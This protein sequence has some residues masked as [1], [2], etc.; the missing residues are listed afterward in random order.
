MK[1]ITTNVVIALVGFALGYALY[2]S[3]NNSEIKSTRSVNLESSKKVE[4]D[5]KLSEKEIE[6]VIETTASTSEKVTSKILNLKEK[7]EEQ[8]TQID[9]ASVTK[10]VG[11]V[12]K[13]QV[14]EETVI[15]QKELIEWTTQHTEQIN[16]LV[17]A[18]M[19]AE[20]ADHMKLQILKDNK[21]LT[22]TEI[23]QDPI[24]DQNW[25]FN[26]EQELRLLISQHELSEHFELLKLSCK[27]L[28]CDILGIEKVSDSWFK[29]YISLLYTAANVDLSDDKD[30][31]KSVVYLE[32]DVRIVYSQIIFKGS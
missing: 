14:T 9:N 4:N 29:L 32:G 1:N 12:Q 16:D 24:E 22:Q 3:I 20:T 2:P 6:K 19:S 31:P 30:A 21:F 15:V 27:Q 10:K 23:K 11:Q 28:T 17:S 8:L 18:H 26:M 13:E 5:A 7:A 25:A